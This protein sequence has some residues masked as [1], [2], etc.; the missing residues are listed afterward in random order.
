MTLEWVDVE[1]VVLS[2]GHLISSQC[3]VFFKLVSSC[4]TGSLFSSSW[5]SWKKLT[6]IR[7]CLCLR[8]VNSFFKLQ[9]RSNMVHHYLPFMKPLDLDWHVKQW[10][11]CVKNQEIFFFYRQLPAGKSLPRRLLR[12]LQSGGRWEEVK[13]HHSLFPLCFPL[14]GAVLA[15]QEQCEI[16][17]LYKQW[18][19]P[20]CVYKGTAPPSWPAFIFGGCWERLIVFQILI[21]QSYICLLMCRTEFSAQSMLGNLVTLHII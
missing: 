17:A 4:T 18:V 16:N 21:F 19:R 15:E 6:L 12:C 14:C 10:T 3:F 13:F 11:T 20:E 1:S 7:F 9:K 5:A 8:S 2:L